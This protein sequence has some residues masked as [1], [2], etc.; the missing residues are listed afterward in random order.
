[1]NYLIC[2]LIGYLLGSL[3]LSAL[4]SKLTNKN[5]RKSGTGNLGATNTFLV[6]GKTY[7]VIVM[8]VDIAKAFLAVRL[9]M[10][11][12]PEIDIAGMLAGFG[13]VL[14]HIFPFYM[15]FKGGKGLAAFGGMILG[16]DPLAFLILLTIALVLILIVNYSFAMPISAAILFPLLTWYRSKSIP[17]LVIATAAGAVIIIMHAGNVLKARRGAD[18]KIREYIKKD[19]LSKK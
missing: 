4:L 5:L 17:R 10:L 9:A 13:A 18:I 2:L 16:T 12:F 7:G 19:L 15:K 11:L 8:L 6:L 14:G 1:M 3:S